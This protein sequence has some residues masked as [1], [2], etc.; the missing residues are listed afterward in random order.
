MRVSNA[1]VRPQKGQCSCI[2]SSN[3]QKCGRLENP[4][5]KNKNIEAEIIPSQTKGFNLPI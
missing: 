3:T 1:N 2:V 4:V 5:L